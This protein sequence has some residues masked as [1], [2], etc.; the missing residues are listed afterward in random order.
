MVT[1][2]TQ[3]CSSTAQLPQAY[4]SFENRVSL[5]QLQHSSAKAANSDTVNVQVKYAT[6]TAVIAVQH[7]LPSCHSLATSVTQLLTQYSQRTPSNIAPPNVKRASRSPLF[8]IL[9]IPSGLEV[10]EDTSRDCAVVSFVACP[11]TFERR[12]A[13]QAVAYAQTK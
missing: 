4:F 12:A 13:T 3:S 11:A 9:Q 2:S 8:P 10:E 1:A 6:R 5:S 7:I